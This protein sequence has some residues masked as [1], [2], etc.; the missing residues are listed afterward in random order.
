[1]GKKKKG[2]FM[3]KL[4]F[5]LTVLFVL[6]VLAINLFGGFF[7]SKIMEGA[8]GAPVSGGRV[9]LNVLTSELGLSGFKIQNPPGFRRK[10]LT[11]IREISLQY[12]VSSIFSGQIHVPRMRLDFGDMNIEKNRN[13]KFNLMELGAVKGMFGGGSGGNKGKGTKPSGKAPQIIIDEVF[14][15]I[16]K[17]RYFDSIMGQTKEID[18]GIREERFRNVTNT[19]GLVRDI[20]FLIMRKIG[21]SSF[22]Q[23]FLATVDSLK[24]NFF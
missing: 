9:Y 8:I 4:L 20:V 2:N 22:G 18:L 19:P 11:E 7:V 14:V 6:L 12:D 24:R 15:N 10:V 16:G 23:S 21:L 3:I 5:R 1:M 17:V 13:G